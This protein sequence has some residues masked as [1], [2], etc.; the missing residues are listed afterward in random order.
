MKKETLKKV[1]KIVFEVLVCVVIVGF[2]ILFIMTKT[3]NKPLFIG[4]KTTMWVMT[5]SMSPT[6]APKTYI[7]V[8][9]VT[10]EDVEVGD[11]IVFVSTDPRIAGQYNTH[12]VIEI[13]GDKIVTKGDHNPG[14]DGEYS[15][16]KENVVGRYVRTLNVM[17]F[18]GRVVMSPVG[19][20]IVMILFLLATVLCVVPSVKEAMEEKKKEEEEAKRVEMERL[21][22]EEGER[23]EREGV[24][25]KGN[26]D[27]SG[28]D[29]GTRKDS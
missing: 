21:V 19:F 11:I 8:E 27:A 28:T 12:R 5:E 15:A 26:A 4:G 13:D 22:R 29:D 23:L 9:E 14:D 6:I 16:K 24:P 10:A 7:L 2:F 17:T 18:L 25:S 3:S 1:V 20:I